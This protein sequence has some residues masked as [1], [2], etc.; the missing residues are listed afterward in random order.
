MSH[1]FISY[2]RV[3]SKVTENIVSMLQMANYNVWY[4]AH[5]SV[6]SGVEWSELIE[7]EIQNANVFI[8]LV[9][10]NSLRS[11]F[12]SSEI[13]LALS[14]GKRIVPVLISGSFIELPRTLASLAVIDMREGLDDIG[15]AKLLNS[16]KLYMDDS[17]IS[18]MDKKLAREQ[19]LNTRIIYTLAISITGTLMV[20][21]LFGLSYIWSSLVP[22]LLPQKFVDVFQPAYIGLIVGFGLGA[23]FALFNL[24]R[25]SYNKRRDNI[26][27]EVDPEFKQAQQ[28]INEINAKIERLRHREASS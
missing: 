7:R 1:V 8:V 16:L 18:E 6:H 21:V 20:S 4:D 15:F 23:F 26:L 28:E 11:E 17:S 12:V 27:S 9:S 2:S 22:L 24:Y 25:E 5:L 3:D 13:D 10:P 19:F 14:L